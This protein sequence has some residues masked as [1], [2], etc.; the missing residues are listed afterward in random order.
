MLTDSGLCRI[1]HEY[2]YSPIFKELG[3]LSNWSY[4]E[5]DLTLEAISISPRPSCLI[6][7]G[8]HDVCLHL[9]N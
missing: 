6:N 5:S 7:E 4:Q 1:F 3:N 8:V 9:A 2:T